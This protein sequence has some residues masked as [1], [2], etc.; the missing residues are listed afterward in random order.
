MESLNPK[1]LGGYGIRWW[2]ASDAP[3]PAYF[4]GILELA[5]VKNLYS[6]N[7]LDIESRYLSRRSFELLLGA[8]TN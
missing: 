4:V 8:K 1:I 5:N 2:G 7:N 3:L 6:I